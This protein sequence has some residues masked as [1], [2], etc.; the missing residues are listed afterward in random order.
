MNRDYIKK[1]EDYYKKEDNFYILFFT[2][3]L[4]IFFYGFT[5]L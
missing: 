2:H 4:Y 5:S 3:L 1:E